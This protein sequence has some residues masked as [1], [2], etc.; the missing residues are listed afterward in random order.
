[1]SRRLVIPDIHGCFKTFK[2]LLDLCDLRRSDRL[3]LLG[4]Y[5]NRG[6]ASLQVVDY[7]IELISMGYQITA[8][9][10][11]HEDEL[12]KI[13]HKTKTPKELSL[14]G[15]FMNKQLLD[16]HGKL[17][18]HH[19]AFFSS[20]PF[21]IELDDCF[22][23]H[24]GF[25]FASSNPLTDYQSMLWHYPH[26]QA[27]N[28]FIKR[29]VCGHT[30]HTL[31]AIKEQIDQKSPILFLDNGCAYSSKKEMGNLL[32]FDIDTNHLFVNPNIDKVAT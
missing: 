15:L 25:N 14:P 8:L 18:P 23:V 31:K 29:V 26:S 32:C 19:Y 5:I 7:I 21:Y 22:L 10:G 13:H 3:Y 12:L 17:A 9:R 11:N 27:C 30:P 20:L 24:A 28:T 6:P 2:S 4:D 1:M 16:K